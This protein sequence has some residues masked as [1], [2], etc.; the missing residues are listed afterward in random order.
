MNDLL[1]ANLEKLKKVYGHFTSPT[2][3]RMSLDH[4]L[5]LFM[6]KNDL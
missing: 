3:K 6:E 5:E 1:Q 2:V 4:I